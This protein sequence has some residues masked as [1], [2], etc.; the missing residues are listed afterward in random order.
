MASLRITFSSRK[1]TAKDKIG[2]YLTAGRDDTTLGAR[3]YFFRLEEG[4]YAPKPRLR[5]AKR[6]EEKNNLIP[7]S[8]LLFW[9]FWDIVNS[10]LFNGRLEPG[11]DDI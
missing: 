11:Y 3:G 7:V 10:Y 1:V 2:K 6:R 9:F 8:P 5:G 4:N